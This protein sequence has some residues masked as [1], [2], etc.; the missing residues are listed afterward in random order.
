[1]MKSLGYSLTNE[2]IKDM[3]AEADTDK[4]G[5]IDFPEFIS[6]FIRKM[7]DK[8]PEEEYAE[9][10]AA[11]DENGNGIIT[12][13]ELKEFMIN[14]QEY[15]EEKGD[16]K[17]VEAIMNEADVDG[18]GGLDYAEFCYIMLCK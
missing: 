9:L 15:D 12:M 18:D 10:F 11:I 14:I 16:I 17:E 8:D 1:M 5:A 7:S 6:L 13:H 3:I 4:K 2:E